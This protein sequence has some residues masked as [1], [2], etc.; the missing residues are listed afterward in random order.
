MTKS[1]AKLGFGCFFPG[2]ER[3]QVTEILLQALQAGYR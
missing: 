1:D 3:E 2:T